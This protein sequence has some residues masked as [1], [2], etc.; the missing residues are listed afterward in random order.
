MDHLTMRIH[1][2][3]L[4]SL[5]VMLA[6]SLRSAGAER[7][8]VLMIMT[9]DL[10]CDL[11]AYG[12][13]LVQSPHLD[14]LAEEG[15]VFQNAYCNFP[16]CGPSRAS[17]MT[18]LYPEQNGVTSLR[19]LFR[20]YVPG[21]LTLSQHFRANGYTPARVGKIYHY[22]NPNGIGTNGHD[23]PDSWDIRINP[24]GRD[25]EEEDRIFSLVPGK[26]GATLSWLAA[27]GSDEEQ[28]DGKVAAESIRLLRKFKE[29][30]APFFLGVG[31]YK[32][33]TPFVA[34]K[35]YFDLYDPAEI[36]VP[37]VPTG[38]R[39]TIP[40]PAARRVTAFKSQ[41]DLPE[42]TAR[43]AIH[44]YYATISFMDAQ[45]G[46]VLK[47]LDKLGL[48][49]NTI[50]LFASDHGY[51]MGEHGHYQKNTLFESADRVPLIISYPEM[52]RKGETTAAL[53][54]MIDFY[55]TL[56]DLAGIDVAP[57]YVQGHS[58]VPILKDPQNTVREAAITQLANGYTI[59]TDRY[60]YTKWPE[61]KGPNVELY[62][63]LSDPKEM[64]NL[65][66]DPK[67]RDIIEKLDPIWERR[68][69]EITQIPEGL[70]FVKPEAKDNGISRDQYRELE[71][72]GQLPRYQSL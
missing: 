40:K 49:D 22:D 45:I 1:S 43:Q 71:K 44:A 39:D 67:Y 59:R 62:D 63:R 30:E 47:E 13:P 16:L 60:R 6:A 55:K 33:H 70:H 42:E 52:K 31:F 4:L 32:P 54:E 69:K 51:H 61:E 7:L 14:R 15:M 38:Y 56:A 37:R 17:F 5:L 64:V 23:D 28:T 66:A 53:V 41:I 35:K 11:G 12:H 20:H 19:R 29:E 3:H 24:I 65:A 8:N 25:K 50:V 57:S 26:F 2:F 10:N 68:V 48:K 72:A 21:A 46:R 27:E 36:E 18:G 58:L 34:P 9:D